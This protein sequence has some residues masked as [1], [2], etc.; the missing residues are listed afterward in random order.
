LFLAAFGPVLGAPISEIKGRKAVYLV[1]I[2]IFMLFTLGCGLAKNITT[3][4]VCRFLSAAAGS[5]C[6]A[7]GA[8]TTA[9]LWDVR[10]G[11]GLASVLFV[12]T[13]FSGTIIGPIVGG[14]TLKTRGD[15]T[16]L[17]WA[18]LLATGPLYILLLFTSETSKKELLN[19]RAKARGLSQ[20]PKPPLR[21]ALKMLL[22]ITFFRPLKMLLVEPIVAFIALYVA[23]AFGVL[24]AFFTAY[25]FVF[26][27]IYGF[28]IGSTNLPFISI[29]VGTLVAVLTFFIFDKTLYKKA[30]AKCAPGAMP[31]AEKR[32]YNCLVGSFGISLGLF[33]FA[34]TARTEVHWIVPIIAGLSFGWGMTCLL[35]SVRRL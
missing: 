14:Y 8:G 27:N 5:P 24:F 33:W 12:E 3:L 26:E 4:L 7:I 20:A 6:L 1:T 31:A 19:R 18:M 32:L 11:G 15:W 29:F 10:K 17:M 2:P 35:V 16:W 30:M 22:V 23:F 25:P 9:D 28:D 21:V 13:M 34:W